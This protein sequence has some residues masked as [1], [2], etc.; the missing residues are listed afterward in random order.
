M[1]NY[2]G[3]AIKYRWC[4]RIF[5]PVFLYKATLIR[6][7]EGGIKGKW[8]KSRKKGFVKAIKVKLVEVK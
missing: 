1:K 7:Y 6:K 8:K 4:N 2:D 3:W 5:P